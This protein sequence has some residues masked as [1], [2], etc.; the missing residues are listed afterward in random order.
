MT[1]ESNQYRELQKHLHKMPVGFPP[2]KSGVE[3]SLLKSIFT[4]E[5][6]IVTTHLHYKLRELDS[7]IVSELEKY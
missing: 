3:V 2:T 4:P 5:Q 6:A 7:L 1:T